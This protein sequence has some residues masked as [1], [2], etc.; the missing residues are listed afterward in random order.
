MYNL[1]RCQKA[2]QRIMKVDGR[3]NKNMYACLNIE[4]LL[5]ECENMAFSAEKSIHIYTLFWKS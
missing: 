2:L 1:N 4:V 5:L 3:D